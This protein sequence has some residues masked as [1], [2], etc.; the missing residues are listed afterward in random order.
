MKVEIYGDVLCPWCFIGKRRVEAAVRGLPEGG[1]LVGIIWRSRELAP[2]A[3]RVPG[4]TA[5]EAMVTWWGDRAAER[6]EHIRAEGR[7]EGLELNLHLARPVS[8]FDAHRLVYLAAEHNLAD[9]VVESLFN[10]Y[11]TEGRNIADPEVLAY[12][13]TTA[14]LPGS[15]V[16]RLLHGDAYTREVRA[17]EA[18]ATALG[19]TGVPSVVIDGRSP[20]SGIQ[21]PARLRALL[22]EAMPAA[23]VEAAD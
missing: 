9:P 15:D 20:T 1:P 23:R 11:H 12:L 3:G 10:A 8:T 14:G 17:D 13:G 2:D 18:R 7:L 19:I 4:P 5:A 6:I 16:R 22:E 21:P